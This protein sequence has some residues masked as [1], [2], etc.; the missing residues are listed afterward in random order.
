MENLINLH[1]PGK[2]V[3]DN[4]FGSHLRDLFWVV[5]YGILPQMWSSLYKLFTGHAMQ[6]NA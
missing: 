4:S 5:F 2:F 1:K 6:G 3:E